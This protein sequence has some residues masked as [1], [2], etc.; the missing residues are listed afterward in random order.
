M[1]FF[2]HFGRYILLLVQIFHRPEKMIMYWRELMRQMT[3]IG[4]ESIPIIAVVSVFIGA[5]TAL[6]FAYQIKDFAVP[7]YYIGYIVR[8]T[9]IIEMAPTMSCLMLA[10]KVGSNMASELGNMRTSEQIDALEIMGINTPGYL[11]GTKILATLLSVPSLVVVAA[12]VGI[13]GGLLA[14]LLGGYGTFSDYERG[15]HAFFMPI[16]INLMLIKGVVFA[17]ILSSIACYQGYHVKGGAVQIG[18]ASTRAVVLADILILV[19]DYVIA[20]IFLS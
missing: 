7:L 20:Q 2:A 3:V 8:D 19:S 15:L 11:V 18:Q 13:L 16:N 14:V 17:F 9:M 4:I 1:Q 6:Q 10:G 12:L 5:V